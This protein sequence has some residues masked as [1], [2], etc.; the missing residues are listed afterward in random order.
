MQARHRCKLVWDSSEKRERSG[1]PQALHGHLLNQVAHRAAHPSE[2]DADHD[3]PP[4]ALRNPYWSMWG[5]DRLQ[6]IQGK[7][8]RCLVI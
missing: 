5:K 6:G 1:K 8:R 7:S 3:W 4:A 2:S